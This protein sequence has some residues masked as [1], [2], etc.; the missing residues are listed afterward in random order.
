MHQ[1]SGKRP[2][3]PLKLQFQSCPYELCGNS[4]RLK[5]KTYS[6]KD[7]GERIRERQYEFVCVRCRQRIRIE[8][9]Q[10]RL[11]KAPRRARPATRRNQRVTVSVLGESGESIVPETIGFDSESA[12]DALDM[13]D[14]TAV[15]KPLA[16]SQP[17]DEKAAAR[18]ERDAED[19]RSLRRLQI[20]AMFVDAVEKKQ[21]IGKRFRFERILVRGPLNIVAVARDL[22]TKAPVV[23][24][25]QPDTALDGEDSVEPIDKL[26]RAVAIQQRMGGPGVLPVLAIVRGQFGYLLVEPFVPGRTLTKLVQDRGPLPEKEVRRIGL[27]LASVL[28]RSVYKMAGADGSQ[29]RIC[30]VHRDIKPDNIIIRENGE[31][32]LIDW[33]VSRD[34]DDPRDNQSVQTEDIPM[35]D[36]AAHRATLTQQGVLIGTPNFMAPEQVDGA[37]LDVRTDL[38]ALGAALYYALV[39]R[40]P[41]DAANLTELLEIIVT[42]PP[43]AVTTLRPDLA[44]SKQMSDL[45]TKSLEKDRLKR[46]QTPEELI[47]ALSHGQAKPVPKSGNYVRVILLFLLVLM[48]VAACVWGHYGYPIPQI[49]W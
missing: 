6:P 5:P 4:E 40:E 35:L 31:A 34:S 24:K 21:V 25:C 32:V 11:V 2:S 20:M 13:A 29:R 42:K 49:P 10:L 37:P 30:V 46:F 48:T 16:A 41:F 38:Y 28:K 17:I 23:V 43:P 3:V 7:I 33:G 44:I 1:G 39:R 27:Q 22:H 45:L 9:P 14:T 36:P 12:L 26:K 18:E 47:D 15:Q 8:L 19:R